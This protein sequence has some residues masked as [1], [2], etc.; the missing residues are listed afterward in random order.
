MNTRL[1]IL[2]A[3]AIVL[4]ACTQIENPAE[5]KVPVSL[6]YSAVSATE[7]KAAQNLNVIRKFCLSILKMVEICKPKLSMRK[8]RFAISQNA[9]LGLETVLNF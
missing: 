2:S 4:A 7:T 1:F 3:A 5:N 6:T 8:K 9:E